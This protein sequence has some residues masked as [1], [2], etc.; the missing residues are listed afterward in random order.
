M[1]DLNDQLGRLLAAGRPEPAAEEPGLPFGLDT[2][3]IAEWRSLRAGAPASPLGALYRRAV[4]WSLAI[5]GVAAISFFRDWARI[6]DLA[7]WENIELRLANSA[8]QQ[9]LP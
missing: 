5:A 7:S 6:N 9:H 1:N 3:V 4:V 2:R 8:I